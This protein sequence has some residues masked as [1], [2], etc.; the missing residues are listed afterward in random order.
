MSEGERVR[1]VGGD[2]VAG[3]GEEERLALHVTSGYMLRRTVRREAGMQT[4]AP[5]ATAFCTSA[6][7]CARL[8]AML[9]VE[10]S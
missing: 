9:A 8:C 1:G 2:V 6:W 4:L 10:Q 5:A 3:F 7:H